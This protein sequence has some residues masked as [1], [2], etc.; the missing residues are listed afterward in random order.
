MYPPYLIGN[1]LTMIAITVIVVIPNILTNWS[2][3]TE[4][5]ALRHTL[6][7]SRYFVRVILINCFL[8]ST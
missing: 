2:R 3:L 8:P 4:I 5:N 1:I 6:I 7:L